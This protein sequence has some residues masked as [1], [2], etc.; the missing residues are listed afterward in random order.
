M[1]SEADRVAPAETG[2]VVLGWSNTDRREV[3]VT[4]ALGPGPEAVHTATGFLPDGEWH[5]REVDHVYQRSG[6][7]VTYLGDWHT[8]PGGRGLLSLTDFRTLARISRNP[9]ARAPQPLMLIL[10]HGT[11]WTLVAW[12]RLTL[13]IFGM[14]LP[15][16]RRLSCR[17]WR[18]APGDLPGAQGDNDDS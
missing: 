18:P 14:S 11:P 2:G 4:N 15:W 8:H 6:R 16:H 13:R 7:L 17:T 1:R 10:A 9:E 5:D 3:V 12:Q